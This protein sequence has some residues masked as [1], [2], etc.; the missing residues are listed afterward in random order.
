[1]AQA[2]DDDAA[3]DALVSQRP[4]GEGIQEIAVLDVRYFGRRGLDD[5]YGAITRRIDASPFA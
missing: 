1:L 2:V 4:A 3:V 5:S